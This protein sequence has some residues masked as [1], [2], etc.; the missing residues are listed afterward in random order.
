PRDLV[1]RWLSEESYW[2]AGRARDV[3][4]RS[5]AGS[6]VAG[7]YDGPGPDT[8]QLAFA[9]VVTDDATFAWICDVYVDDAVRGRGIGTWLMAELVEEMLHRRRILRLLLATRDAHGLYAKSGFTPLQGAWRWMEIDH[10]PTRDSIL[11]T[12]PPPGVGR[13]EGP[14]AAGA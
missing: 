3:F 6:V 4:E 13:A 10:R 7:V 9:R 14:D 1:F 11:A 5:L 8:A 2:A 12:G